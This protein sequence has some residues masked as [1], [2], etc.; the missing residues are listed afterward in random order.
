MLIA[1]NAE[2]N[3]DKK[4][5]TS[6]KIS[7]KNRSYNNIPIQSELL[8]KYETVTDIFNKELNN[9][10]DTIK[11]LNK[12]TELNMLD[13]NTLNKE[14]AKLKAIELFKRYNDKSYFYN[15]NTKI[16][17]TKSGIRESI[18]KIFDIKSQRNLLKEH[19][20]IISSLGNIIK[21]AKLVNQANE[22]K[23]RNYIN[24]WNYYFDGIEINGE[25]YNFEFE[26]RS[27]VNGQNQYR[28]QRLQKK[29]STHYGVAIASELPSRG[30]IALK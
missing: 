17:V 20:L 14:S 4:E 22:L 3:T 30:Q 7:N 29:Q 21:H 27:M 12:I 15:N 24:H 19:L 11:V 23:N 18:Q 9:N 26:V 16:E 6:Y 1:T 10:I 5:K 28:I 25:L 13:T 2:I 8:N